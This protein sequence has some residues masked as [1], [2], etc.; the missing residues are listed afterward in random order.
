M[1]ARTFVVRRIARGVAVVIVVLAAA[2]FVASV[3]GSKNS[4][5]ASL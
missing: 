2:A 3:A 4:R 5:L 1:S